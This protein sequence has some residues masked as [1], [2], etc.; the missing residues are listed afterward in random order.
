MIGSMNRVILFVEDVSGCT[1]FYRD[2]LGLK[3]TGY[4]D[5]GWV[6]F[7]AGGCLLTLHKATPGKRPSE[8]T[9]SVQIVFKVEDVAATR[10]SLMAKGVPMGKLWDVDGEFAFCDGHDPEGNLFQISSR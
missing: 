3:Q 6:P 10:E 4:A 1:A 8:G 2:V 7:D 9:H 5:A